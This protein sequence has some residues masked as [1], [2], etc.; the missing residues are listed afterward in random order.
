MNPI[1]CP[2]RPLAHSRPPQGRGQSGMCSRE[3]M[4]APQATSLPGWNR[5]AQQRM[6]AAPATRRLDGAGSMAR[7]RWRTRPLLPRRAAAGDHPLPRTGP[8]AF[9]GPAG[10]TL[11]IK[12]EG[13]NDA[14]LVRQP[15][16][17]HLLRIDPRCRRAVLPALSR[18]T[19][20]MNLRPAGSWSSAPHDHP[21]S[22]LVAVPGSRWSGA[23]SRP[24]VTFIR[25]GGCSGHLTRPIVARAPRTQRQVGDEH[26]PGVRRDGNVPVL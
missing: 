23:L 24:G 11:L 5:R 13:L 21:V 16:V 9:R 6:A 15:H 4:G 19:D 22:M 10:G 26:L 20:P 8:P 17:V 1:P 2:G 25:S 7:L 14:A 18:A 3:A 12:R